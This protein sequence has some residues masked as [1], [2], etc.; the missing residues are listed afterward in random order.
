MASM[1]LLPVGPHLSASGYK[2]AGPGDIDRPP[3]N[4]LFLPYWLLNREEMLS[5]ILDRSDQNAPN[6]ASRF[7]LHVRELKEETLSEEGKAEVKATF[8]VDSPIPYKLESLHNKLKNDDTAKGVGADGKREVKGEW[9]GR[10]VRFIS[11]LEAKAKDR[12]YGF[13]FKPPAAAIGYEWLAKQVGSLLAPGRG[14]PRHQNRGFLRSTIRRAPG[15]Y[16]GLCATLV[17]RAILDAAGEAD[18]FCIR[19]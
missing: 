19:L 10:L 4:A 5:M 17:R 1:R 16:G 11:R 15:G 6:Q 8:T 18:A 9:E 14:K 13:M 2:I 7:T 3:S 12:R